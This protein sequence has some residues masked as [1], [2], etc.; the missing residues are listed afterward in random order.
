MKINKV[1]VSIPLTH[2]LKL[3]NLR[4]CAVHAALHELPLN[5]G[6]LVKACKV[7]VG[8]SGD[9]RKPLVFPCLITEFYMLARVDFKDDPFEDPMID[10]GVGTWT[11]LEIERELTG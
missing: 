10:I 8:G 5:V 2:T 4:N 11:T 9:H 3:K 7:A 1:R 6:H